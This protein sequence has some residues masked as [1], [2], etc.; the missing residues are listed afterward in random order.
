MKPN[1]PSPLSPFWKMV[2]GTESRLMPGKPSTMSYSHSPSLAD[3]FWENMSSSLER[4]L[5]PSLRHFITTLQNCRVGKPALWQRVRHND[6][7]TSVTSWVPPPLCWTHRKGSGKRRKIYLCSLTPTLKHPK[8][9][10]GHRKLSA[11]WTH[12]RGVLS[13]LRGRSIQS[14]PQHRALIIWLRRDWIHRNT[15]KH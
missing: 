11:A 2:L 5:L 12:S 13:G 10:W 9:K 4:L 8:C 1:L 3:P 7:P 14:G 6:F 15:D